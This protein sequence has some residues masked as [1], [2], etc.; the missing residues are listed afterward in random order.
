LGGPY[1]IKTKFIRALMGA[2]KI[3]DPQL[4]LILI[5]LTVRG[6]RASTT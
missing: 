1:C 2:T 5:P 6:E 4:V 3:H